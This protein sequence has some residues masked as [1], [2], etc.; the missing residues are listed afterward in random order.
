MSRSATTPGGGTAWACSWVLPLRESGARPT[1]F[2]ACPGYGVDLE[3]S[4]FARALAEDQPIY[5][6][7]LPFDS[8]GKPFTTVEQI[9][10]A[11]VRKMR[12]IQPHGPYYLFGHSF[13]G[14]V[15]YE[16]ARR[17]ADERQ[18]VGMVAIADAQH[19]AYS[20]TLPI[21]G[22]TSFY[23]TYVVDR[24]AKYARNLKRGRFDLI[25]SD[26]FILLYSRY[27]RFYWRMVC[28][29]FG[30]LGREVPKFIRSDLLV[31]AGSWRAYRP[32]AYAGR[33]VLCS[34]SGRPSE[35]HADATLGWKTCATGPIELHTV[36]GDHITMM[37][38]PQVGI[39]V[40]CLEPYLGAVA[41]HE[42]DAEREVGCQSTSPW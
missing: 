20:R 6:F 39:L 40:E 42:A 2:W 18:D 4:D 41:R 23:V 22:R 30:G 32:G 33:V 16:M 35:Y 7:R 14:L 12:E 9:A 27:R 26:A 11:Y 1:I 10:A 24:L 29:V 3:E 28:R 21:A 17:L 34:A 37:R 15:V 36:P 5:A 25:L 31:L 38:M 19:P 13:C 8:S